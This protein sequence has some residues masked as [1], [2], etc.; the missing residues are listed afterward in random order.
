M[1]DT[2]CEVVAGVDTHADTCW[3]ALV[4]TAGHHID[5]QQFRADPAGYQALVE[6]ITSHGT[7]LRVGVEGT[8]SYGAG[9]T[10]VLAARGIPTAEVTRPARTTRRRGKSDPIDAYAAAAA[11]L[12]DNELP[13]PKTLDQV[14]GMIRPLLIARRSAVKAA[15]EATQ[16]IHSL[17]VTAPD[18]IREPYRHLDTKTLIKQ[19]S[20]LPPPVRPDTGADAFR[21]A[22][23]TLATRIIALHNQAD[24]LETEL[25]RLTIAANPA[26]A[27]SFGIGPVTAAQLLVTAGDNPTRMRSQACFAM[28]I[29]VCP[30]PASSGKTTRHR[31]NRHGDRQGNAAIEHIAFIRARYD[32]D[33]KDYLARLA[34]RGKTD[35]EAIRCLKRAIARQVWHLL[36][37]PDQAPDTTSLRALRQARHATLA[38]ASTALHVDPTAISRLERGLKADTRLANRYHDWLTTP[39][40]NLTK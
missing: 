11:A 24:R 29:G 27:G 7:L 10:R 6:F 38:Q 40:P 30:I 32:P 26:L 37:H 28:L 4:D 5:D 31:L 23:H 12:A 13:V 36:T 15:A 21:L 14:T 39:Q 9:L 18:Q 8:S 22:L 35:R 34:A 17:L 19:L 16:Q 20:Q 1:T 33:T 3:A 2:T 25:D